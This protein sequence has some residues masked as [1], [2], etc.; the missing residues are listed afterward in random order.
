MASTVPIREG[1]TIT[2]HVGRSAVVVDVEGADYLERPVGAV[3]PRAALTLARTLRRAAW[4][5]RRRRVY[6]WLGGLW[7][8][9]GNRCTCGISI[10]ICA[11]GEDPTKHTLCRCGHPQC[12]HLEDP[13]GP[14]ACGIQPCTCH[15]FHAR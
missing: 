6:E 14:H 11:S 12:Q 7:R 8:T 3:S 9:R 13:S 4:A 15:Q 1:W 2:V 5:V 10:C